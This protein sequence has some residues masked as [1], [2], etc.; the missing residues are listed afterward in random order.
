VAIVRMVKECA[1]CHRP[2]TLRI[3]VAPV[4]RMNLIF[5]C[6][7]CGVSLR[8][9]LTAMEPG[10]LEERT[11]DL[12]DSRA[13]EEG[14]PVLVLYSDLPVPLSLL[15]REEAGFISAFILMTTLWG[16]RAQEYS[17][18]SNLMGH[19]RETLF[20]SV[21]RATSLYETNDLHRLAD[22]V[23]RFPVDQVDELAEFHPIYKL[24]RVVDILY[25]PFVDLDERTAAVEELL[26]RMVACYLHRS[27][28]Y[29]ALLGEFVDE[30]GFIEHRRKVV[31]TAM[32]VL[33]HFDALLPG[34]AWEHITT[35]PPPNPGEYRIVRGDFNEL[36]GRYVEIFELASRSLV[37]AGSIL[38]L[39]ERAS[40][41]RWANGRATNLRRA[42]RS[43]TAHDREFIL[44]ELP[45]TRPI[46]DAVHR[47]S[48]NAFGHYGIEYD[49]AT[50]ELVDHDGSRTSYVLFLVDYLAAARATAYLMSVCE[51]ISLDI[52]DAPS[53]HRAVADAQRG[54]EGDA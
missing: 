26:R 25:L 46:Y 35:D 1:T 44:N 39:A 2:M 33:D 36:R 27:D 12:L 32:S 6:P 30:L 49:F 29:R 45:Q 43:W 53:G 48:R 22:G 21:R 5:Q 9:E 34:L 28:E 19:Q 51:K 31:A 8:T 47:A 52:L 41:T 23:S 3:G 11:S 15:G 50:G 16:D 7:N 24:Q 54:A 4:P 18:R 13:A 40:P 17:A 10:R 37:F 42:L 14:L 20:P 38:N